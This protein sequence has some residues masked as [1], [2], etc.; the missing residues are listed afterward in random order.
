MWHQ[1]CYMPQNSKS[2]N[3]QLQT[4]INLQIISKQDP[5]NALEKISFN[6]HKFLNWCVLTTISQPYPYLMFHC[7]YLLPWSGEI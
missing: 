2:I 1:S 3:R 5:Y 7:N 6:S 4:N